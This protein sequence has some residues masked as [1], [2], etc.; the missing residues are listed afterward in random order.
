M[1]SLGLPLYCV[2][3]QN[4]VGRLTCIS[5]CPCS[6]GLNYVC[7][8]V[9]VWAKSTSS[10]TNAHMKHAAP[11]AQSSSLSLSPVCASVNCSWRHL[12]ELCCTLSHSVTLC[13]RPLCRMPLPGSVWADSLKQQHLQ[14]TRETTSPLSPAPGDHF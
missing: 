8:C 2:L 7:V 11:T 1:L 5:D 12:T 3:P 9:C 13:I 14:R 4:A 10:I 6:A